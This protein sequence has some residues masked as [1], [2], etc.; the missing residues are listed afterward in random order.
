MRMHATA[1]APGRDRDPGEPFTGSS[2]WR[3]SWRSQNAFYR[4]RRISVQVS[5]NQKQRLQ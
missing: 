5:L 2:T 3:A 1:P 4:E